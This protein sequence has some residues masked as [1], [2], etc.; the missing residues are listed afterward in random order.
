MG[1]QDISTFTGWVEEGNHHGKLTSRTHRQQENKG[2]SGVTEATRGSLIRKEGVV[3]YIECCISGQDEDETWQLHLQTEW[4]LTDTGFSKVKRE[5]DWSTEELEEV[6]ELQTADVHKMVS[7]SFAMKESQEMRQYLD[8]YV[9]SRVICVFS[10][11]GIYWSMCVCWWEWSGREHVLAGEKYLMEQ[12]GMGLR[13]QSRRV[14]PP[15]CERQEDRNMQWR[16][17]GWCL[18]APVSFHWNTKWDLQWK[19][20]GGGEEDD[21]HMIF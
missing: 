18:I 16:N 2:D 11:S 20:R 17:S 15:P 4:T 6:E 1:A 10:K 19:W 21:K 13:A 12:E 7:S 8:R 9:G 5:P 14:S 3:E